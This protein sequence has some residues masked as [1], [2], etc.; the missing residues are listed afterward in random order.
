MARHGTALHTCVRK[1]EGFA[2]FLQSVGTD[3]LFPAWDTAG[4]T[5]NGTSGPNG[6][7]QVPVGMQVR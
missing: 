7:F 5:G 4:F 3:D 2:R 1:N 6:F